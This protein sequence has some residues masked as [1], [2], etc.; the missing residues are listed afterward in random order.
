MDIN[1]NVRAVNETRTTNTST[2]KSATNKQFKSPKAK[3]NN[4]KSTGSMKLKNFANPQK[5][6]KTGLT[7]IGIA[8]AVR[9]T[10]KLLNDSNRIVGTVTGNRFGESRR[11]DMIKMGS[12]PFG[13]MTQITKTY[14]KKSYETDRANQRIDYNRELAGMTLPYRNGNAGITL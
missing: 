4:A 7:A 3:S 6:L 12:N 1:I 2:D 14:F 9:A 10:A 8:A 11:A 13:M 5:L